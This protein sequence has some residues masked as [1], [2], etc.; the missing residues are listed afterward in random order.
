[1]S[2]PARNCTED[3]KQILGQYRKSH[4]IYVDIIKIIDACKKHHNNDDDFFVFLYHKLDEPEM[5]I[6][7]ICLCEMAR[8]GL[9]YNSASQLLPQL[10][11]RLVSLLVEPT[12]TELVKVH[13]LKLFLDA[14][15]HDLFG[16][17][18]GDL[19]TVSFLNAMAN[20]LESGNE[21]LKQNVLQ[22]LKEI[23]DVPF[24]LAERLLERTNVL[25]QIKAALISKTYKERNTRRFYLVLLSSLTNID[26]RSL[27]LHLDLWKWV[28]D[29]F[30][31]ARKGTSFNLISEV[32]QHLDVSIGRTVLK[33]AEAVF[34]AKVEEMIVSDSTEIVESGLAVLSTAISVDDYYADEFLWKA[35]GLALVLNKLKEKTCVQECMMVVS[36]LN[37]SR[38]IYRDALIESDLLDIL[39]GIMYER[40]IG[41]PL[42][43]YVLI[44]LCEFFSKGSTKQV[45]KL[46]H[47]GIFDIIILQSQ[48][49][50][51]I[52]LLDALRK[53]IK[54][55]LMVSTKKSKCIGQ[56]IYELN[57]C[58]VFNKIVGC[59]REFDEMLRGNAS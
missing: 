51:S 30:L 54:R 17:M 58:Q 40:G 47:R 5:A 18:T 50:K 24:N 22:F 1:M 6:K 20:L 25:S 29:F 16:F 32:M 31:K 27:S 13:A 41:R 46:V 3:E 59:Q 21:R 12:S 8:R 55:V 38:E 33:G 49:F 56:K 57:V 39:I 14:L 19:Y 37:Y 35:K 9:P 10:Y 34:Y 15:P 23:C 36:S 42:K 52:L 28:L 45:Q 7:E 53:A 4:L 43:L 44:V 2:N 11:Y 26:H 48:A